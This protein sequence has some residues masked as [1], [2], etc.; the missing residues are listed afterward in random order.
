MG[1]QTH[2]KVSFRQPLSLTTFST[3][4]NAQQEKKKKNHF[5]LYMFS[6]LMKDWEPLVMTFFFNTACVE[7]YL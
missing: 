1:K 6:I 2:K 7:T 5:S 4:E 3:P